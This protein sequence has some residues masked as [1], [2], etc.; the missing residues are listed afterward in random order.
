VS[1]GPPTPERS[2]RV[3][4]VDDFLAAARD[5]VPVALPTSGTSGGPRWVVRTTTSWTV[6]FAAV[7]DL[8]GL[9]PASRVWVPGPL[10][11]TMNLFAAVHAAVLGASLVDRVAGATHAVLTPSMLLRALADD[12]PLAGVDVVVAGDRLAPAV[13]D[14]ARAAGARVHH[15]Y[16][17]AELS[18]VAW[19]P[20]AEDLRPFPGVDVS[21]REGE[22]WARSPYLCSGYDGEPGPLRVAPDGAATVGDRGRLDHGRLQ[23]LGRPATATVG[24][25][26]VDL[27][28]VHAV[29]RPY[30]RGEICVV[31]VPHDVLGEV[32][33]VVLTDPADHRPL[34][35]EAAGALQ[36]A[37]RPRLWSHLDPLPLTPAGK[38]DA[39]SV[40]ASLAAG[41]ARRLT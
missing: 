33:A 17:A 34:R 22:V 3:A 21:V 39:A 16:G 37:A 31:G 25:A 7:A 13:H 6:S 11:A 10:T 9:R 19:G 30:A 41:D 18:F 29:L 38:V 14:R 36:G 15:Y 35:R 23:V 40:A 27:A 4:S 28:A 26:T 1:A 5:R 12:L 2:R 24:G 32:V 20:H 8:T